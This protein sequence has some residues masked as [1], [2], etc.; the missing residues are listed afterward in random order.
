MVTGTGRRMIVFLMAGFVAVSYA[1]VWRA[2]PVA[3]REAFVNSRTRLQ[4]ESQLA[5]QL[6]RLPRDASFLMYLGEHVGALQRAGIPLRRAISEGNHRVWMQPSD[7]QG[8]WERSLADPVKHA[9]F[10][11]AAEGDP[12]WLAVHDRNLPEI[13]RIEVEGQRTVHIWS[14]R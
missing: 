9:D 12:V 10:V 4:L 11:V 5:E 2:G 8:L 7:P 3:Y 6:K 14:T 1:G 13:A